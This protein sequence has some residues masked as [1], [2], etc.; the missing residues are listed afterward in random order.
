MRWRSGTKKFRSVISSDGRT[1]WM[2]ML[3]T[4]LLALILCATATAASASGQA[5]PVASRMA[6]IDG[7]KLHYLTAG[8]GP[9]VILIHGYTQTSRMWRPIIPAAGREIYGD[10]AR[11]S[12]NRRLGNPEGRIGYED[13][14]H[15]H[16]R[17][18][19]VTG[20]R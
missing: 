5:L 2:F 18:C 1:R 11:P 4:G 7:V 16:T 14:G 9:T 6:Q 17:S 8:H 12:G 15:P 20:S 13:C 10:C 19:Q 3:L